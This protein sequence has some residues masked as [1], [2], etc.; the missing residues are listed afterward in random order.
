[1]SNY[2]SYLNF[3]RVLIVASNDHESRDPQNTSTRWYSLEWCPCYHHNNTVH[4]TV[5]I[6]SVPSLILLANGTSEQD[7][8]VG[9]EDTHSNSK[10]NT[11]ER[12]YS[13]STTDAVSQG[14]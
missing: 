12:Q 4:V 6:D 3:A 2:S 11:T 5:K 14:M 1:M 8:R 7:N 9:L 10:S 13:V